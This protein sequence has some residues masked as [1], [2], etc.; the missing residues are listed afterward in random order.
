MLTK[1]TLTGTLVGFI[2][3]FFS[4]WIFYDTLASDFFSQH[5]VNMPSKMASQMN[6]IAIGVL[7]EAYILSLIYSQWAKG[8]YN[9]RNG[10]KLGALFGLFIGLG[11]NMITLGTI[12]LI[13]IQG[14]LVDAL[15]NV[16]CF[17]IA[18]SLNGWIFNALT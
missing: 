9:L 7:V 1:A 2:F 16:I 14:S 5:Y 11:I 8:N 3:L 13:N 17:G 18:G 6:Y 15:W 10:F 12:E 4:G